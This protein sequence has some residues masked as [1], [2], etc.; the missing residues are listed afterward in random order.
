MDKLC[1]QLVEILKR[2]VVPATG[3][4]EPVAIALAASTASSYLEEELQLLQVNLSLNVYKNGLNVKIPVVNETGLALSAALG[5]YLK[6]PKN[7]LDIFDGVTERIVQR[8]KLLIQE[9]KVQVSPVLHW[10]GL[11][12]EVRAKGTKN[13]VCVR[14]EDDHTNVTFISRNNTVIIDNSRYKSEKSDSEAFFCHL[15]IINLI[16]MVEQIPVSELEF[17]DHGVGMNL[18]VARL[19]L[20][21]RRGLGIGMGLSRIMEKFQ[22]SNDLVYKAKMYTAASADVRM[23]GY[24]VPVM[25]SGGSGNQ[26]LALILPIYLTVEHFKLGKESLLRGLAIGHAVNLLVKHYTG[27]I[28]SICGCAIGSGLGVAVAV[29]WMLGGNDRQIVGT[30]NNLVA[31]L[32]GIICDG[33]KESCSL[34]LST[35]AGEAILSA[36]LSLEDFMVTEEQALIGKD[37]QDTLRNLSCLSAGMDHLEKALFK[38]ISHGR[39]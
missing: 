30:F 24:Q 14:V 2:E 22:V 15:S 9:G 12:I 37:F 25:T 1:Q 19:G 28:L 3:C 18:H 33:A 23:S 38:I 36:L 31:N 27:K 39:N 4:T 26:G 29:C 6:A 11:R 34:K 35:A 10:K 20:K 13:E 21:H 16:R 5:Y 17:L 8:A 32:T 7:R